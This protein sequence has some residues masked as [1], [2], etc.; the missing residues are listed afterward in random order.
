[1]AMDKNYDSKKETLDFL[2][3]AVFSFGG[4]YRLQAYNRLPSQRALEGLRRVRNAV[5]SRKLGIK[6]QEVRFAKSKTKENCH[7]YL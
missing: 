6:R 3:T 1:M 7:V 4:L 5:I 2:G